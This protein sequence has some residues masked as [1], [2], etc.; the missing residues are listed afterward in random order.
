MP[1]EEALLIGVK[2]FQALKTCTTQKWMEIRDW[3]EEPAVQLPTW[4]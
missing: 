4:D 1:S 2:D 3:L